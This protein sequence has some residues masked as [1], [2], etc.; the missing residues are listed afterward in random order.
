M[1]PR[2]TFPAVLLA[3]TLLTVAACGGSSSAGPTTAGSTGS[4][5]ASA[6]LPSTIGTSAPSLVLP[7]AGTA[8]GGAAIDPGTLLSAEMAASVIGGS[9]TAVT[10]PGLNVPGVGIAAYG[11]TTGDTVAVFVEKVP[12]GL[13]TTAQLQA[14]ML[15]AGTQ[16]NLT[17]ITGLGDAA[18]TVVAANEATI[19]FVKSGALVVISAHSGS[20]AGSALEPKLE[21]VAQQIAGKL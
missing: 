19:A 10:I 9:P 18:G 20:A 13:A 7:S 6:A 2:Q 5:G 4:A 14:A 16:G 1:I 21:S 15:M 12:G 8:T 3:A 17:P 11:T